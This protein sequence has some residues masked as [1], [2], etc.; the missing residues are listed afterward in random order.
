[1]AQEIE[2]KFLVNGTGWQDHVTRTV[3]IRQAY[4]ARTPAMVIRV[5]IV[6]EDRALLTIKSARP[7]TTR[8]EFEYPIPLDDAR[9]LMDLRSG[10]VLRK[11]RHVVAV[12]AHEWEVDV[13]EAPY[14]G[15]VIA[16]LELPE[17]DAPFERPAWLGAEVTDDWHYYNSSLAAD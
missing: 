5:R 6:D 8:S 11:R 7:G 17:R 13:F 2:R 15:L 14:R 1:M 3:E 10:Q 9:R 16:E 12:G 4:L